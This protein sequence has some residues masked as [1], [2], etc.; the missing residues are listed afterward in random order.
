MTHNGILGLFT[1]PP[2]RAPIPRTSVPAFCPRSSEFT[3]TGKQQEDVCT[4][5]AQHCKKVFVY[6]SAHS[7]AGTSLRSPDPHPYQAPVQGQIL[8][9]LCRRRRRSR[10]R[11][12]N[13]PHR[14]STTGYTWG[15]ESYTEYLHALQSVL[16]G[17]PD[18]TI[19]ERQHE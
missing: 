5:P 10:P 11:A 9:V 15:W 18:K 4:G 3:A 12:Q 16:G 7:S 19:T 13:C 14:E 17:E 2:I 6:S 1:G 8:R